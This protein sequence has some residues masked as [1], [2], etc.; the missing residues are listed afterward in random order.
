MTDLTRVMAEGLRRVIPA[1]LRP[2]AAITNG[3]WVSV[4]GKV[5]AGPFE[6]MRYV[7]EAVGSCYI[8]KLLGTYERELAPVVEEICSMTPRAAL[9]L[10]A[11]EGYYAVG[12]AR[13]VPGCKVICYEGDLQGRRLICEMAALNGVS[14]Q[15]D[16]RGWATVGEV[17]SVL[18]NER[19]SVMICD[20]EGAEEELCDPN[21]LPGLRR[22]SILVETH[23]FVRR[24]ITEILKSRFLESHNLKE[25]HQ[26]SRTRAD[27][28]PMPLVARLLPRRY[29]EWAVSEWRPEPMRWLWMRAL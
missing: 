8:P 26:T 4:E 7:K 3:V 29:S 27:F 2:I 12:L 24:G 16:I 21:L 25:I 9:V 1:S 22:V 23:D 28:V 15:L 14:E 5:K 10:G 18:E 17:G 13:R 19:P 20:V 11:G 6:G